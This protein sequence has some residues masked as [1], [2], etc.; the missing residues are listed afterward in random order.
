MKQQPVENHLI[1]S[2]ASP[3]STQYHHECQPSTLT[4]AVLR[5]VIRI[6]AS[7]PESEGGEVLPKS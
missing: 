5:H 3:F 6:D 4:A 1:F 7:S 2:L